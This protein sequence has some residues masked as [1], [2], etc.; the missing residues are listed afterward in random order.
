MRLARAALVAFALFTTALPAAVAHADGAGA[1]A[2]Q[3]LFDEAKALM[4]RH[5]YA[6]ACPKLEEALRFEPKGNGARMLL[7]ECYESDKRFASAWATYLAA[8]AF[9]KANGQTD[10]EAR[11]HERATALAPRLSRLRVIVDPGLAALEGLVVKRDHLVLGRAQ[12][13][14]AL[15]LDGGKHVLLVTADGRM[16]LRREIEVPDENG[17]LE[18]SL[19]LA[20]VLPAM[21]AASASAS[22]SAS[23]PAPTTSRTE[24][25]PPASASAAAPRARP[26]WVVPAVAGGI[27][28]AVAAGAFAWDQQRVEARQDDLCGGNLKQCART[29]P[30]YDPASDNARK[31]RDFALSLGFGAGAVALLAVSAVG[32]FGGRD[33]TVALGPRGASVGGRF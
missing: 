25:P 22:A 17:S 24:P 21:P 7:G 4:K 9:A 30:D 19:G 1:A 16:P 8:E 31:R 5:A 27:V 28:L 2:A 26:A 14:D 13:G 12:W 20:D 23:A 15:P 32:V 33:T 3:A 6:E 10:R 18:V 11:A 29:T